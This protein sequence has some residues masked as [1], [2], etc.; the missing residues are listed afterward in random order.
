MAQF[1]VT[2][3]KTRQ[4][5]EQNALLNYRSFS[6]DRSTTL[7]GN[8]ITCKPFTPVNAP[9]NVEKLKCSFPFRNSTLSDQ[10]WQQFARFFF[11]AASFSFDYIAVVSHSTNFIAA[12]SARKHINDGGE[13]RRMSA[14]SINPALTPVDAVWYGQTDSETVIQVQNYP[15]PM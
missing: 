3:C 7:L 2:A 15:S 12:M 10:H 13:Q 5:F 9:A 14:L 8:C 6:P 1:S 4:A 11:I